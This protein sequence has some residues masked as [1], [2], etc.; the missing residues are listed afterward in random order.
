[1]HSSI[2]LLIKKIDFNLFNILIDGEIIY[3]LQLI[4]ALGLTYTYTM[5]N[6]HAGTN[7]S[8]YTYSKMMA[9]T[10]IARKGRIY[11]FGTYLLYQLVALFETVRSLDHGHACMHDS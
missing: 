7:T 2:S 10:N 9:T 5:Y 4:A 8:S 3:C 6:G 1:M 11:N